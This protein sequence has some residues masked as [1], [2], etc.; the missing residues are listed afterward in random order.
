M[1]EFS[2]QK[3][4]PRK[5]N[6]NSQDP[7]IC[8]VHTGAKRT[9]S[10]PRV[11]NHLKQHLRVWH[12]K[13]FAIWGFSKDKWAISQKSVPYL[14][15]TSSLRKNLYGYARIFLLTNDGSC[16]PTGQ[17]NNRRKQTA[18]GQAALPVF[19]D[20][21][22]GKGPDTFCRKCPTNSPSFQLIPLAAPSLPSS[23]SCSL[24]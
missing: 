14:G 18:A 11:M 23:L 9:S 16:L 13:H 19:R 6:V 15:T 12:Y 5:G 4:Q 8:Q 2:N 3:H 7:S 10:T 22:V 24:F 21:Q 20:H 1:S 17:M